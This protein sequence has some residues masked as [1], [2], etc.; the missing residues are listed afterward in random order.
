MTIVNIRRDVDD[1]FYRYRMPLLEIKIEGRGNGIKTVIPNMSDISRALSRPPTYPTKYFGCELGAQTVIDEKGDRYI[2]NG[3]HDAN[4]LREL[5]DGFIDRFVLCGNC[6]NPET[7]LKLKNGDI[8]RDCKAC[9]KRTLVDMGHKLTTYINKNPPPK[10]A[11]GAKGAGKAAGQSVSAGGDDD[12]AGGGSDDELTRR[13]NAEAKS[14]PSAEQRAK[15]DADEDWSV[16]TS[17]AAVAARVKALEGGMSNVLTLGDDEG[18]DDESSPYSQFGAWILEQRE[19]GHQPS[20]MDV[21]KKAQE[22][23]LIHI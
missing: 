10:R 2:V 8:Y 23:S 15:T 6:K 16:D 21:Y 3:A 18:E 17:E 12:E 13:I 11:K 5:L 14:I 1:R 22:L 20:A 9:G 7:D 19:A 4:R